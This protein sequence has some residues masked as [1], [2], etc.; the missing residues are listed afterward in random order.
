MVAQSS[1]KRNAVKDVAAAWKAWLS[2][3]G[4]LRKQRLQAYHWVGPSAILLITWVGW[5]FSEAIR[6]A[7]KVQLSKGLS[8]LGIDAASLEQSDGWAG[9]IALW[10]VSQLEWILELGIILLI[11]WLKLKI[12][13]YLLLT[14]VAPFM[15]LLAA[16]IRFR[17]TGQSSPLTASGLIRDVFRGLRTAL[18]LFLFELALTIALAISGLLLLLLAPPVVAILSPVLVA[19][20]WAVGSY[21]Y[22]AAVF[23]AVFEQQG[24]NWRNSL[25]EGWSRKGHLLGIGMVFS[26]LMA[27]PLIGPIVAALIGPIPCTA[28]AAKLTFSSAPTRTP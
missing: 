28:A 8:H 3:F 24:I 10:A 7:A 22:G 4:Y 27:I 19:L 18:S 21:F 25:R 14:L 13:K 26:L 20:S 6:Q 15:S 1:V 9:S 5:V 12:T 16:A 23:D 2:A 17:E 11:F